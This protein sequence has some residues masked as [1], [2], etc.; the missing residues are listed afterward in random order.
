MS[1][2]AVKLSGAEGGV[3][4]AT[5]LVVTKQF[6]DCALSFAAASIALTV[7]TYAV[8]AVNPVKV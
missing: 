3:T 8:L 2:L 6:A 1:A 4:S 7:N 5:A